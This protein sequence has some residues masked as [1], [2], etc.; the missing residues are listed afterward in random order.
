M[1]R[2][3]ICMG[4]IDRIKRIEGS[5]VVLPEDTDFLVRSI[6]EALDVIREA[7][8]NLGER[9]RDM[10]WASTN[11]VLKRMQEFLTRFK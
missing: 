8:D 5:A 7:E 2:K 1:A 11:V 6:Y 3:S 4:L 10:V 9:N